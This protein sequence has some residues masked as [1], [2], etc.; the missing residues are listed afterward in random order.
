MIDVMA[1]RRIVEGL[2]SSLNTPVPRWMQVDSV[3]PVRIKAPGESP[4]PYEPASLVPL[5][6]LTAG[7]TV[8]TVWWNGQAVIVGAKGGAGAGI[9]VIT[10]LPDA[11]TLTTSGT[12]VGAG[13][14]ANGWPVD[15]TAQQLKV[16]VVNSN[17]HIWQR[18]QLASGSYQSYTRRGW[19]ATAP[20]WTAWSVQDQSLPGAKLVKTASQT[21]PATTW[22]KVTFET[23]AFSDEPNFAD[24]TNSRLV[25]PSA[26]RYILGGSIAHP[27]SYSSIYNREMCVV[28]GDAAPSTTNRVARQGAKQDGVAYLSATN[29]LDLSAG[30]YLTLWYYSAVASNF[31]TPATPEFSLWAQRIK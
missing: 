3:D 12:Y 5:T 31:G 15:S 24:M 10:T 25:I 16:E 30:D 14:A 13:S 27:T 9:T 26:G 11:D 19:P 4:L 6:S 22:T 28:L 8:L 17:D 23:S 7:M 29:T 1:I 18:V 20:T 2:L 21:Y